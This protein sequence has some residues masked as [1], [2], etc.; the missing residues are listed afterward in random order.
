[1]YYSN[2]S[3]LARYKSGYKPFILYRIIQVSIQ[4]YVVKLLTEFPVRRLD[5]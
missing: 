5:D 3:S 4:L 2:N 1:M